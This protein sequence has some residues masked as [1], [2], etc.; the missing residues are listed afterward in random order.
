M[1]TI[2]RRTN[3]IAFYLHD[4]YRKLV[5]FLNLKKILFHEIDFRLSCTFKKIVENL[6]V[7]ARKKFHD[8]SKKGNF[9]KWKSARRLRDADGVG[10]E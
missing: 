7:V 2:S 10:Y 1:W 4:I 3:R 9:K 6:V 8:E 5:S